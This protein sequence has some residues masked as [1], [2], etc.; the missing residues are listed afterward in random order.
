MS[1]YADTSNK[2]DQLRRQAKA[3]IRQRPDLSP[4]KS[5][6][7]FELMHELNIHQAELEIQNEE[8]KRAQ[9]ELSELHREYESLYEFAPCGY[10]TLNEKGI[11]TRA[12]LTTVGL[13]ETRRQF[14]IHSGFSRFI[15]L[16][17]ENFF[18]DAL[19]KAG[20]TGVKQSIELPLKRKNGAPTWVRAEIE[21]D[22]G[23]TGRVNQWRMVLVDITEKK[24]AEEVLRKDRKK[25][26]KEVNIRTAEIEKQYQQLDRLNVAIKKMAQHTLKA[27]ESERKVMS[28]D[29][30]DSIGGSLSAI[31]LHLETRIS[32]MS[33]FERKLPS[34]VMPLEKLVTHLH[35]TINEARRISNQLRPL[36]LDDLGL[37]SALAEAIRQFKEFYPGI[38]AVSQI[39]INSEPLPPDIQTVLYRVVQEA[40]NN[41]GR[42]SAAK[43]VHVKLVNNQQQILLEVADDGRGFDPRKVLSCKDDLI[44]FGIHS[45]R[46][47]VEICKGKFR[48]QSKPGNGTAVKI[49]IPI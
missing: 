26:E 47:R 7:I 23:E 6:G 32:R 42:H 9:Q 12:N 45:M 49:S 36:A 2:F 33:S 5:G 25:L 38:K 27:M 22:Q 24:A 44:G 3:L 10:V 11:I 20:E 35:A 40:L 43:V 34:G 15:A 18:L 46:E 1:E 21:A 16:G 29:I 30:H 19:K 37:K 14:L 39:E 4:E 13:L 41:V 48:I 31:K 28:K 8:L 17:W